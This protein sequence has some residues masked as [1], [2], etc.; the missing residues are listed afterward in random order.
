MQNLGFSLV[1]VDDLASKALTQMRYESQVELEVMH[2]TEFLSHQLTYPQSP[3]HNIWS[4]PISKYLLGD[5]AVFSDPP[6]CVLVLV[7]ILVRDSAGTEQ[8]EY[9]LHNRHTR[10]GT[11][12]RKY[13]YPAIRPSQIRAIS[14]APLKDTLCVFVQS[15]EDSTSGGVKH[16]FVETCGQDIQKLIDKL[17]LDGM[18]IEVQV[19]SNDEMVQKFNLRAG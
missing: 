10:L 16:V 19:V 14:W 4:V 12:D 5:H 15:S 6:A 18:S 17:R 2:V 3:I 11:S 1:T 7:P 8:E 13:P 9:Q